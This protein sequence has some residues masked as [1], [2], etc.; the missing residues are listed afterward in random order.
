[1]SPHEILY[2]YNVAAYN[3]MGHSYGKLAKQG[4]SRASLR[5][6]P[7][8]SYLPPTSTQNSVRLVS[9]SLERRRYR[10]ETFPCISRKVRIFFCSHFILQKTTN[11][12]RQ[13]TATS[14]LTAAIEPVTAF[15]IILEIVGTHLQP[16][17]G[18]IPALVLERERRRGIIAVPTQVTMRAGAIV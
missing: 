5:V 18:G 12:P 10:F 14:L 1:M 7:L 2:I 16:T 8:P 15:G 11:R 3:F 13:V 17:G 9:E 6:L 4:C